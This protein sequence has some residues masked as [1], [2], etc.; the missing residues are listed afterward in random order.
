[1]NRALNRV[2]LTP[3]PAIA[4]KHQ[5][6]LV[7]FTSTVQTDELVS[8][9]AAQS[10]R[11]VSGLEM[12]TATQPAFC[13]FSSL[14]LPRLEAEWLVVDTVGDCG[15]RTQGLHMFRGQGRS[16]RVRGHRGR[17]VEDQGGSGRVREYQGGSG[18]VREDQGGSGRAKESWGESRSIKKGE[19]LKRSCFL[20]LSHL[21]PWMSGLSWTNQKGSSDDSSRWP[22]GQLPGNFRPHSVSVLQ[23]TSRN[24]SENGHCS[25][26]NGLCTGCI[27]EKSRFHFSPA[28]HFY[29]G[30][31]GNPK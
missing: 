30:T 10:G 20:P 7:L 13:Y 5:Q 15:S 1:M 28:T 22:H 11:G 3:L 6:F 31:P 14:A 21:S 27:L 8:P 9:N 29:G 19:S 26:G 17:S 2:D 24:K 23:R 4:V 18:K 25:V 16:R 12:R